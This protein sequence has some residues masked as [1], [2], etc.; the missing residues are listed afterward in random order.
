M[1]AE[2][3]KTVKCYLMDRE[4]FSLV[5]CLE[6]VTDFWGYGRDFAT[7]PTYNTYMPTRTHLMDKPDMNEPE[8]DDLGY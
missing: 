1:R 4:W 7:M 6:D 5:E 8:K 3:A 2:Y